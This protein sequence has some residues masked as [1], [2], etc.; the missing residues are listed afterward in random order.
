M[1]TR[2]ILSGLLAMAALLSTVASA[3][4]AVSP[5][6]PFVGSSSTA[7]IYFQGNIQVLCKSSTFGGTVSSTGSMTGS[8]PTFSN[9]EVPPNG[10]SSGL[11]KV[12]VTGLQATSG[13]FVGGTNEVTT[14]LSAIKLRVT[15]PSLGGCSVEVAGSAYAHNLGLLPMTLS[16]VAFSS[17][18][19]SKLEVTNVTSPGACTML[20]WKNMAGVRLL[21]TYALSPALTVS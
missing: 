10:G 5:A 15:I 6:G 16:S 9:C 13:S 18:A 17:A 21:G 11:G 2:I 19:P 1:R 20:F 12:T 4:A 14:T 7:D 8:V 3:S